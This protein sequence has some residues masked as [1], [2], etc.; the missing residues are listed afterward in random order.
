[1]IVYGFA[2]HP[3]LGFLSTAP[4][5]V[6][7]QRRP[8]DFFSIE[9]EQLNDSYHNMGNLAPDLVS[10]DTSQPETDTLTAVV[11][12]GIEEYYAQY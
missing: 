8:N 9:A 6:L 1:V 12:K 4:G 5:I 2:P 11:Y 7:A 10:I 3:D